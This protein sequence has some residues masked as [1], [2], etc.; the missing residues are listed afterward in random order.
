MKNVTLKREKIVQVFRMLN[1][2]K[3]QKLSDSDKVNVWKI[4]RTLRPIA[5]K[6]EEDIS[7]AQIKLVP[8]EGFG[9]DLNKAKQYEK[10]K[11]EGIEDSPMTEE[12]YKKFQ[13]AFNSYSKLLTSALKDILD[14][15]ETIEFNALSEDSFGKLM[16]SN[17]WTFKEVESLDFII[18]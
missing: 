15:E 14:Q 18:Q 3:Y 10:A 7:D 5:Q 8:Y 9:M 2:A 16:A 4:V 6:C 1:N 11:S 17:D 13:T 12:E